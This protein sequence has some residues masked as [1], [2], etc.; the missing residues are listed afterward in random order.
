[1]KRI[2]LLVKKI[3][4][5][6][7]LSID[8]FLSFYKIIKASSDFAQKAS[9]KFVHKIEREKKKRK[10]RQTAILINNRSCRKLRHLNNSS[11]SCTRN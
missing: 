2:H 5:Y 8:Y 4:Y 1:M 7:Y 10:S 3:C 6:F 9:G 11:V